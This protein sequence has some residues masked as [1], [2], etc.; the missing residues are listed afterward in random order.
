MNERRASE[1]AHMHIQP[2]LHGDALLLDV[3][4]AVLYACNEQKVECENEWRRKVTEQQNIESLIAKVLELQKENE[5]LKQA[6]PNMATSLV[7]MARQLEE[8][9][10]FL[11]ANNIQ[12]DASIGTI[13]GGDK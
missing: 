1:I 13:N 9:E 10:K 6:K 5:L 2:A 11:D 7:K 8:Y 4:N 12:K 3:R